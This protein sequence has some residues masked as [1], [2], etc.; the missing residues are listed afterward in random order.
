MARAN[1]HREERWFTYWPVLL[2]LSLAVGLWL[3]W[4]AGIGAS[5]SAARLP[6]PA[7]EYVRLA[8]GTDS[9]AV[10]PDE[11]AHRSGFGI[12]RLVDD[13]RGVGPASVPPLPP[14]PFL[15]MT[16][17]RTPRALVGAGAFD[18]PLLDGPDHAD[19][20]SSSR[21]PPKA[22]FWSRLSPSLER[23]GFRFEPPIVASTAAV[24]R[25]LFLVEVGPDGRVRHVLADVAPHSVAVRALRESLERGSASTNA[26]GYV[27][28]GWTP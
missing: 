13:L 12:G 22:A 8:P 23:S 4:P 24:A 7:A 16:V 28:A 25:A 19:E 26:S 2:V 20:L 21:R 27:D 14:P 3:L 11:F 6:E 1:Y 18:I 10:R 17:A 5:R 9:L 15:P